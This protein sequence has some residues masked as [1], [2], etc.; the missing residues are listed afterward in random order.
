MRF[1][2]IPSVVASGRNVLLATF[3][4]AN[5]KGNLRLSLL[6][7]QAR[8]VAISEVNLHGPGFFEDSVETQDLASKFY[9]DPTVELTLRPNDVRFGSTAEVR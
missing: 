7:S 5:R 2:F 6:S 1:T 8:D 9:A 4:P 3:C